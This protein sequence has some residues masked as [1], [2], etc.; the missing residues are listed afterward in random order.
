MRLEREGER[1]PDM[2]VSRM[3]SSPETRPERE[4]LIT[5]PAES[6]AMP[7]HDLQQSVSGVHDCKSFEGSEVILCL[8]SSNA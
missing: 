1:V 5:L 8:K 2:D 4:T 7:S 3:D 6:Q